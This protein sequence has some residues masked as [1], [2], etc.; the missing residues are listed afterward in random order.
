[1]RLKLIV[2]ATLVL[3]SAGLAF[4]QG[5]QTG[6]LTGTVA[7][8]DGQTLPGV[9]VTVKSDALIGTRT[10]TTDAHGAYIF[11]A[12]PSGVYKVT[13]TRDRFATVEKTVKIDLG[14]NIPMDATLA[15]AQVQE[16]VN[17]EAEVPTPLSTSEVGANYKQSMYDNLPT[18][19][20]LA[21]VAA[22]APGLTTNTPN[23]AQVQI[24]GNFAY[25]NRFLV[26]GAD[27]DDNLYGSPNPIFIEDAIEEMQI[28][29]SGI[30]AEY[31]GF[32]GGV[33]NA[34]TKRGGNAYSGSLRENFT[35]P[36]WRAQ[37]PYEATNNIVR[38]KKL[39]SFTEG[40][41]GGPIA[42]DR[43]WF[44]L[45]GRR[46]SSNTQITLA[47]SGVPF[48]QTELQYRGEAKLSGAI[49]PNHNVSV[50]YIGVSDKLHRL[51]FN[52][53]PSLASID[54]HTV[55][56]GKQPASIFVAN[57]NGV[58][59]PNLF[60]DL[61]YS[62][63]KF[64]F[65]DSGGT[66]TNII[67]SPYI[68]QS[69]GA[70]YNAPYFDA[71]DPEDR[72]NRQIAGSLSYFLSSQKLG[73]HDIKVG[74]ENY[75]SRHTGGNSQSSTNYVFYT[76]YLT[77]DA[78]APVFDS[79]GYVIPVFTPRVSQLQNWMAV[80]GAEVDITTQSLYANDRW[81]L[82]RHWSFNVGVRAEWVKGTATAGI[83]PVNTSRIVPRL[84]VTFDPRGDGKFKLDATYSQ[85]AGKYSE[86]QFANNTNVGN[87]DAIYY[88]YTG[89]AGQ[90]RG[91]AP[92]IDPANYG[93]IITGVF[94][95]ANVFYDPN[96][97]SPVT[98]EWT[99]AA[100]INLGNGGYVKAIYTWRKVTDF[101]QDFVT[102]A[103]GT[104]DVVKN[105]VD[106]GA[107]SNRRWANSNDGLRE[108]SALQF[109]AAYRAMQHLRL[110]GHYT[111]MLKDDGNQEGEAANQPGA[112]S[113]F[114]GY[115]PEIFDQARTYP[116]GHFSGFQQHRLR[117]WGIY[118]LSLGKKAGEINWGLVFRF[119]SGTAYSIRSTGVSLTD[120]QT[121]IG[122]QFYPDLPTS[123]TVFYA[124]GRGSERFQSSHL[125]DLSANYNVPVWKKVR[126]WVKLE[127]R[128]VFNSTP[129][130]S[131]NISTKP[132][133]TSPLDNLGLPTGYIKGKAFGTGTSTANYPNPREF[134]M[135]AGI[136]F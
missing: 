90:G 130:I 38:Q 49:A 88:R 51:P 92:G 34:V 33:I 25:D 39:N 57:Y 81:T 82:N 98:K 120:V 95:T 106:Y 123:Q 9:L 96:I 91:F 6:V 30:S 1:M 69:V 133:P 3:A 108:Y 111:L 93:A 70:E 28:L 71:T 2:V 47:E 114:P 29:T 78:G 105:G 56:D 80:R 124:S 46:E 63:K 44:F 58:L 23:A 15:L 135:S 66:S 125:F 67:D 132:D 43:V 97:K 21:Q 13:F 37:T 85:Y 77:N 134:L 112:P 136:R 54:L 127:V 12:L 61:Q 36:A 89:P 31:G 68:A 104:T 100:G 110:E 116:I 62:Q 53:P 48:T 50:S 126:P 129:L 83:Q 7:S 131:Y 103:T 45:A 107:L 74:Y 119:D 52:S 55:Y 102:Q 64:S 86:T 14:A 10:A 40:T 11:K 20:T 113:A 76:D 73:K 5:T 79:N 22:L 94:P 24:A 16:T 35:D 122:Q 17:V 60:L 4:A 59:R 75:R 109:Q 26:D 101:V 121:A 65:Q 32:G 19:R 87:P 72:D 118:D 117:A 27:V 18:G 115:Y 8:P 84:G 99:G 42:K 41:F 128:N